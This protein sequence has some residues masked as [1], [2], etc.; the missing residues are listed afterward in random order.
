LF[1]NSKANNNK[2]ASDEAVQNYIDLLLNEDQIQASLDL[3]DD[4]DQALNL[5]EFSNKSRLFLNQLKR[6]K[7]K[8]KAFISR[9]DGV[10]PIKES[11]SCHLFKISG[12]LIGIPSDKI[13]EIKLFCFDKKSSIRKSNKN[14]PKI[15]DCDLFLDDDNE[16]MNY[17]I[18]DTSNLIIGDTYS[19]SK[20]DEYKFVIIFEK[21]NWTLAID[22]IGGEII[23]N[24][25]EV[26]WRSDNTKRKWLLGTVIKKMY[27]LIDL[28]AIDD[29][30]IEKKVLED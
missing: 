17:P 16:Q 11:F 7:K 15:L 13:K 23:V 18:I 3:D 19:V 20:L 10:N 2:N 24:P 21:Y 6:A 22:E 9:V 28:D 26:R 5:S 4:F 30:M 25:A 29:M 12:L 27:A 1:R 14:D 8:S